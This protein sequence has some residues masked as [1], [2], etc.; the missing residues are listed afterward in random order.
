VYTPRERQRLREEL[1]A[2]ARADERITAGAITG[3]AALGRE[4]EWSDI[5]LA[6]GLRRAED[7]RPAL[8][9]WTARM[10]RDHGALHHFDVPSGSWIYRVFLLATTLQ[11]DL[12][13]APR[14]D[15]GA[16][17]PSFRL[18]FGD[19]ATIPEAPS[20][21]A[22]PIVGLAWLYALHARSAIARGKLLQ[23]EYMV[24]GIRDHVLSLACI[25][26]GLPPAQARGIDQLPPEESARLDAALVRA[27][28]AAEVSR[29]FAAAVSC[30][31]DE[32]AHAD[33]ALAER[34]APVLRELAKAP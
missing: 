19:A 7:L 12:A 30:L 27:I 34:L 28:D 18:V 16:R 29:A 10:Y 17:A 31:V 5:D 23:A 8:E 13:F 26:H 33:S 24:S 25:R 4:D 9:D 1:L 20:S 11:V 21:R 22:E 6:F 32:T 2:A 15:F 14:S 3:S